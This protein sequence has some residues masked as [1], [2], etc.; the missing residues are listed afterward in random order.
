MNIITLAHGGGGN[1][2]NELIRQE[3]APRF[4]N[5][6]LASLPD[7]AAGKFTRRNNETV[8]GNNQPL[9]GQ[10]SIGQTCQ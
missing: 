8:A 2:Q 7:V 9:G 10:C 4:N 3:I 1:L 5:S 6:L